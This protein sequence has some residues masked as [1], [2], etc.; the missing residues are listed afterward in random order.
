M[1]HVS[2]LSMNSLNQTHTSVFTFLLH[3]LLLGDHITRMYLTLN[4]MIDWHHFV[5]MKSYGYISDTMEDFV[6]IRFDHAQC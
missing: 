2:L 6:M 5:C 1:L 3:L 4:K